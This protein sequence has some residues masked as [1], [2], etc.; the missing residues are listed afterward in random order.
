MKKTLIVLLSFC[1]LSAIADTRSELRAYQRSLGAS[2]PASPGSPARPGVVTAGPERLTTVTRCDEPRQTSLPLSSLLDLVLDADPKITVDHDPRGGVLTVSGPEMIGNCNAMIEPKLKGKEI[3][4]RMTY[5]IEFAFKQGEECTFVKDAA[6][7]DTTVIKDCKYKIKKKVG[8]EIT[9]LEPS[10]EPSLTGFRKCL[11][12]SGVIKADGKINADG[13]YPEGINFPFGNVKDSGDVVFMS[14]GQ[15]SVT[16]RAAYGS[17][18]MNDGCDYFEKISANGVRV[19]S[20]EETDNLSLQAQADSLRS[21]PLDQ[22][23]QLSDFIERNPAFNDLVAHRE[24]LLLDAAKASARKFAAG[25][26]SD[27]D[28]AVLDS[29]NKYI[30]QPKIEEMKA[31]YAEIQSLQSGPDKTAKQTRLNA[32]KA[33]LASFNQRPYFESAQVDKLMAEG[34]FDAAEK[35]YGIRVSMAVFAKLGQKVNNVDITAESAESQ[36]SQ[37]RVQFSNNIVTEKEK[38]EIRTG[39]SSGQTVAMAEAALTIRQAIQ[40]LAQERQELIQEAQQR[41]SQYWVNRQ[42]CMADLQDDLADIQEEAV[43]LQ[44]EATEIDGK[45]RSYAELEAKGCVAAAQQN[46]ERV[47]ERECRSRLNQQVAQ[48]TSQAQQGQQGQQGQQQQLAQQQAM[49]QQQQ[50]QQQQLMMQ[51]QTSLYPQNSG[52]SFSGNLGLGMQS[53]QMYMGQGSM[54]GASSMYSPYGMGSYGM[55]GMNGMSSPYMSS[56]YMNGMGGMGQ[57]GMQA[58]YGMQQSPYMMGG[59]GQMG[60]GMG[61]MGMTNPG[62]MSSPY[63]SSPYMNT[64]TFR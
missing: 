38:F 45:V 15:S 3:S 59:M 2:G 56:P 1:A 7:A 52:F 62:M 33:E 28:F 12:D 10:F 25:S 60:M 27:E 11:T 47:T 31:L 17:F 18:L 14:H 21:C 36:I 9:N 30:L 61:G 20:A 53:P 8:D 16:E 35:L 49:M 5:A 42:N 41:C 43:A 22:L 34:N 51:Q 64:G 37:I 54:M 24:S 26:P 46:G 50:Q 4:G 23:T 63:M 44:A 29:F 32:L 40:Q 13:I 6:G 55:N 58:G 39:Q 19:Y 48:I 57:M